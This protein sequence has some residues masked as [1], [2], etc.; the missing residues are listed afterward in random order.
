MRDEKHITGVY[1]CPEDTLPGQEVRVTEVVVGDSGVRVRYE[2]TA[3]PP[4]ESSNLLKPLRPYWSWYA[5]DDL[6][7]RYFPTGESQMSSDAKGRVSVVMLTPAPPPAARLLSVRLAPIVEPKED[8][9]ECSFDVHLGYGDIRPPA[10]ESPGGS[11]NNH[12][13]ERS[14]VVGHEC[15]DLIAGHLVRVEMVQLDEQNTTI[16]YTIEPP[17]RVEELTSTSPLT[18]PLAFWAEDDRGNGYFDGEILYDMAPD[19]SISQCLCLLA[20]PAREARRLRFSS[21]PYPVSDA[22]DVPRCSFEVL[23]NEVP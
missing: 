15:S 20:P 2:V 23:I 5:E 6:G 4:A 9:H 8:Q 7:T 10:S 21:R 3:L 1:I 18:A 11:E 13:M 17:L 16:R 14:I 12:A 22:E 19:R